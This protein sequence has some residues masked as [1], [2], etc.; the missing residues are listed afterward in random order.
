MHGE[1]FLNRRGCTDPAQTVRMYD[2]PNWCSNCSC[3]QEP[4]L[5]DINMY[6]YVYISS[7]TWPKYTPLLSQK[8]VKGQSFHQ[9]ATPFSKWTP[10]ARIQ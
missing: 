10:R 7:T 9:D 2:L 8:V 1:V 3:Q 6:P 4:A 5:H